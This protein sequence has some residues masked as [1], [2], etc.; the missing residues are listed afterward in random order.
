VELAPTHYRPRLLLGEALQDAGRR[1]EAIEQYQ[2]AIR[3]K[4][5]E[6]IGYIKIGQCLAEVGQWV[7][8]RQQFLKAI[9]IDP[10]NRAARDSLTVLNHMESRFGVDG[11]GR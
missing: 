4:P 11:S 1:E 7:E 5:A 10:Q 2:A 8:A 3:M 6:P 9:E